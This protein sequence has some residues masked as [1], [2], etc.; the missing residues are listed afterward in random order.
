[1]AGRRRAPGGAHRARTTLIVIVSVALV[2]ALGVGTYWF[3][4]ADRGSG[5]QAGGDAV[6]TTTAGSNAPV[7]DPTIAPPKLAVAPLKQSST[8]P[9][10][11][12]LQQALSQVVTDPGMA[13]SSW[14]VLDGAT[15]KV[16]WGK[17]AD[18]PQIPASMQK[19]L[20]GAAL[21]TAVKD[22]NSRLTTKV[23]Q[24]SQPGDIVFV[25]GGDVTL[26]AAPVGVQSVYDGAPTVAQ[27][28]QQVKASGVEVKRIVLDTGY[29]SGPDMAEGWKT[30]DIRA[31]Y[32][33]KMQPLMVDGDRQNASQEN[34]P[35]TGTPAQTAG[36][37]LARALGQ[38]NLPL[39]AGSAPEGA[40]VLAQVQSQPLAILLSQALLNSDNVL[41]ESLFREVA[42]ALGA[43]RSFTGAIQ[44]TQVAL[45][46][47]GIPLDGVDTFDGSGM[48]DKDRVT[49]DTLARIVS[50]AVSGKKPALRYLLSG[51]PVAGLSGT[52]GSDPSHARF[53]DQR[54]AAGRG[55]VRA[56]T[57]SLNSTLGL[58]GYVPDTDGRVLVFSLITNAAISGNDVGGTRAAQDWFSAVLRQC[59]CR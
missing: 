14:Q 50:A 42:G 9:S 25:G 7:A 11:A 1:M 40:K 20:T 56:K 12:G 38:A 4:T 33:T 53:D 34:S 54:S 55:W 57:G 23:V 16:I 43:P 37:A 28:A 6:V 58:T 39:V 17:A 31:G 44:A 10:Q 51:L 3:L 26:S 52:L 5:T 15:G 22:P 46:D 29:W 18:V 49:P 27:L 8:V 2:A 32:I 59:G 24:G 36:A 13:D 48:S 41:A 47:A 21:L 30:E 35:R 19:L 45:Q